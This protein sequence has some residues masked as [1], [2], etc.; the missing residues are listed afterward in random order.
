M[1]LAAAVA[2]VALG[3]FVGTH[4]SHADATSCKRLVYIQFDNTSY[5]DVRQMPTLLNFLTQR[6]TIYTNDHTVLIS[7]TATGILSTLTG[8]YPDRHGLTVSNSY[9]YFTPS[10]T[11][12]FTSAFKYWTDPVDPAA[13]PLPNL[14]T[15]G[16]KTTPAP[17][18]PFTRA[19]CDVGAVGMANMVP[20]NGSGIGVAIH[21]SQAPTSVCNGNTAAV[22]DLLPDEPGGYTGYK[23]VFSSQPSISAASSLATVEQMQESGVPVTFAY[24]P[25]A[26]QSY[27]PGEAGYV[28]NLKADDD[29]F[30]EFFANLAAHG[31]DPSNTLFVVTTDE[32][33]HFA[34]VPGSSYSHTVCTT[35]TACPAN[36]IGELNV[37]LK[38]LLPGP[39]EIHD[40]LAPAL[41]YFGRPV[42]TDPN[43]LKLA[44]DAWALTSY[45]PYRGKAVS[46]FTKMADPLEELA[47]HMVNA[48]PSRTPTLTLFGNPDF[49]FQSSD[50][51]GV[52]VCANP[53]FA[54]NHGGVQ[55]EIARTWLG[56]V[57]PGV[58]HSGIGINFQTWTDHTNVRPTILA[59]LGLR[60]DYVHDGRVLVEALE[61]SAIPKAM[62]GATMRRL[63]A[64]YNQL[65]APFGTFA[66]STLNASTTALSNPAKY[67]RIE[68]RLA[69][70]VTERNKLAVKIRNALD[71]AAFHGK[72]VKA[73]TAKLWTGQSFAVLSHALALNL[74]QG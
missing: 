28:A 6:G 1:R 46:L 59:L 54:W 42:R 26:H 47:L 62:R 55:D 23:A 65:N 17:W 39:Y 56:L 67:A 30:A 38:A 19:G 34:G 10:G 3:A 12:S 31:I 25:D 5:S 16:K 64:A 8:L 44:Q 4:V 61:P 48:D 35:L 27:G 53:A 45:D 33:D 32:G 69:A 68:T 20:E 21:C 14:I 11:T 71:A 37:N 43:V 63:A 51:N 70:L 18:V 9:G 2:A 50:C 66:D 74:L 13:N 41:Y 72:T 15:T 58:K 49:F 29:A 73:K 52:H 36:Q 24:I 7:H 40:D 22:P 57:G 60:D